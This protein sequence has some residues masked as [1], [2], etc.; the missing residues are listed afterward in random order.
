M[1]VNLNKAAP[2]L[3]S[4]IPHGHYWSTNGQNK[5][6]TSVKHPGNWVAN[7]KDYK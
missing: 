3:E 2:H 7:F 5:K 4:Y 6:K 1:K